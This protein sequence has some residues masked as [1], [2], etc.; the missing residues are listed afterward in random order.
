MDSKEDS[1]LYSSSRVPES[2]DSPDGY[3][4]HSSWENISAENFYP[5]LNPE[6]V[7]AM[8]CLGGI[9]QICRTII[10]LYRLAYADIPDA[11]VRIDLSTFRKF[12]GKMISVFL[13]ELI[14]KKGGSSVCP[15]SC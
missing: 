6:P 2:Q 13:G 1:T 4:W 12:H 9:H 11:A 10:G 8:L 3:R 15:G 7:S 5:S 14:V